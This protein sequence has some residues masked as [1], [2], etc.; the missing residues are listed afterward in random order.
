MKIMRL[1]ATT[2]SYCLC[3]IYIYIYI[4]RERERER[5]MYY[6]YIYILC[7]YIY[8]Y[9]FILV[10]LFTKW[11][12]YG[13]NLD[14]NIDNP[15][16]S[17]LRKWFGSGLWTSFG[18]LTLWSGIA[19]FCYWLIGAERAKRKKAFIAGIGLAVLSIVFIL[20]GR[21]SYFHQ[22]QNNYAVIMLLR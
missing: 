13:Y 8:I 16:S 18:L 21:S 6:M 22:T 20:L 9:I 7:V 4:D 19:G 10:W 12:R 3:N 2:Q 15:S 11:G 17:G 14:V 5:D 1:C